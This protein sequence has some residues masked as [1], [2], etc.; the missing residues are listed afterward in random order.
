M[1]D[2]GAGWSSGSSAA[3]EVKCERHRE[4]EDL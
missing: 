2:Q 1:A 3:V 4:N